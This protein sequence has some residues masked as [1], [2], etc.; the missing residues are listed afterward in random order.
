[1]RLLFRNHYRYRND[2]I[3]RIG[4]FKESRRGL[5]RGLSQCPVKLAISNSSDQGVDHRGQLVEESN[6]NCRLAAFKFD[7]L[8]PGPNEEGECSILN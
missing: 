4:E 6:S 5:L 7:G 3:G 2:A 1:M 8:E